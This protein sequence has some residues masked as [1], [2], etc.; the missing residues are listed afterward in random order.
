MARGEQWWTRVR[1]VCNEHQFVSDCHRP[2]I[3]ICD[4]L[5]VAGVINQKD[6]LQFVLS[7]LSPHTFLTPPGERGESS[8][9]QS[10]YSVH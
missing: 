7:L 3:E 1:S 10:T 5:L 2:L 6:E 4:H 9:T 8:Y